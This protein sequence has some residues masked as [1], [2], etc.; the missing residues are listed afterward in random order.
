MSKELFTV[1]CLGDVVA[2]PG[3]SA[4]RRDIP[5][6][7]EMHRADLIVANGE[8][9]SGGTGIDPTCG[10]EIFETGVDLMTLGD[11][12]W[13]RREARPYLEK[14]MERCIRP[15]NYPEGAPGRGWTV[16]EDS[17]SGLTVGLMNLL[18]RT[19]INIPLDCPFHTA[20]MLL[21]GP[22]SECDLV[23]CDF[24]AEATSEKIALGRYLDGRVS[25]LYGTHTHVATADMQI[26]PSGTAY[27]TDLGMCGSPHGVLGL[28]ADTAVERFL[29][30]MPSSYKAA[31]GEGALSGVKVS[32]ASDD[33]SVVEIARIDG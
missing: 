6:L 32:F 17:E 19:F 9:S 28:D 22:L 21:D 18:G 5:S 2:R 10:Q 7:R 20:D 8:N 14:E 33:L 23:L 26:L 15:A 13:R 27:V 12:T 4:L 3:R 31:K 11:H 16:W 1:I 25:F 24:H 30:G 29:S